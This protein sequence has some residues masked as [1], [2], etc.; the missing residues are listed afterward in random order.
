VLGG[1]LLL[2]VSRKDF[3]GALTGMAPAA[4]DSGSLAAIDRAVAGGAD[5]L[6]VHDVA[7]V[8]DY[9]A[10]RAALDGNPPEAGLGLPEH[11]RREAV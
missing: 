10:V 5:I 9:L 3:I 6:R 1:T 11:L 2:A 7:G 4:R 8:R